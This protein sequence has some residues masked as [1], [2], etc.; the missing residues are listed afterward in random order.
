MSSIGSCVGC[1]TQVLRY[2]PS[3]STV[4]PRQSLVVLL[5]LGL[6]G[7]F[8]YHAVYG[9]YGLERRAKLVE[10]GEVL[11]FEMLSLDAERARLKRDVA[12]LTPDTP[13]ADIVE[14]IARDV[15]G[16]ADPTDRITMS[17]PDAIRP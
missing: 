14:E 3:P 1:D 2:A 13:D 8:G 12:L 15:L 16:F 7:L 6:T 11:E 4:G 9:R 17:A 5:C 10:R